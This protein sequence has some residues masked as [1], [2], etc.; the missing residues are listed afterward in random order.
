MAIVLRRKPWA[1]LMNESKRNSL[2]G[3]INNKCRSCIFDEANAGS[4]LVQV[5]LCSCKDCPLY[6]VRPITKSP[7]PEGTLE[8]YGVVGAEFAFYRQP[9]PL[10]G[11]LTEE[12]PAEGP[13]QSTA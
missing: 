4:W 6:S 11:R 7:I 10:E 12:T 8:A 13:Q 5:T 3:A 9:D 1:V 2:R